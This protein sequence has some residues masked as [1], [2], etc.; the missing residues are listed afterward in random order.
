MAL[1]ATLPIAFLFA[2]R[3]SLLIWPAL[4]LILWRG[5]GVRLLTASAALLLGIVVP[6]LYLIESP[7]NRGGYNF[8]YSRDVIW[9]HWVT[10]AAIIL[11]MVV[12]WRTLAAARSPAPRAG[13]R[14]P[15]AR[16]RAGLARASSGAGKG[17]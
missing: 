4:T 17:T 15:R 8:E 16:R 5:A 6:A 9:A 2:A 12:C 14:P 7:R 10:V 1:L 13:P 3:S 11:L